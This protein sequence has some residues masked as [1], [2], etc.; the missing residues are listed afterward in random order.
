MHIEVHRKSINRLSNGCR[1]PIPDPGAT[2]EK[3]LSWP[4]FYHHHTTKEESG[5]SGGTMRG[6]K[7]K[8]V[9]SGRDHGDICRQLEAF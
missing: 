6:W 8:D 2:T 3:A 9:C 4:F 1:K 5:G 7:F